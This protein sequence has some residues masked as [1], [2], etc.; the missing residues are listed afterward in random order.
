MNMNQS[1]RV[2][3]ILMRRKGVMLVP[4]SKEASQDDLSRVVATMA[5]IML[6]RGFLMSDELVSALLN[7]GMSATS[8]S[9]YCQSMIKTVDDMYGYRLYKPFYRNFPREVM[10]ADT[11]TLVI[12]AIL[13]YISGGTIVPEAK[14]QEDLYAPISN[15]FDRA[16]DINERAVRMLRLGSENDFYTMCQN[17]MTSKTSI[18]S[19]D[20]EM[21]KLFVEV[22]PNM[23]PADIPHKENKAVVIATMLE[24]GIMEHMLYAQVNSVTDVLRVA[25]ALSNGDVSL[26]DNTRYISFS[27]PIRKWMMDTLECVPGAIEEEMIKYRERWIRIGERIHP[28]SFPMD[29]Y[30]R[31]IDA[32]NLL[33]N[34]EQAIVPYG[35]KVERAFASGK[36][37]LL[38]EL[39]TQR[40]GYFAR[41]LHHMFKVFPNKHYDIAVSFAAVAHK[42]A[43]PVLLQVKSYYENEQ[44]RYGTGI[45]FPKGNT[46]RIYVKEGNAVIKITDEI[47][48]LVVIACTHGLM[49]QYR[50]KYAGVYDESKKAYIEPGLASYL[51]PNSMRSAGKALRSVPR[52]SRMKLNEND[53][54]L[55]PFIHWM[56]NENRVDVDL[57][58][59]FFD[60]Q[61]EYMDT[62]SY[63]E[64]RNEYAV[65]SGDFTNAPAPDGA[66]EFVDV[67]ID[68][69]RKQGVRYAIVAVHS[70]TEDY[71]REIPDCFVGYMTL[72]ESEY[73][74]DYGAYKPVTPFNIERV[75]MK[76]DI[77]ND[78]QYVVVCALDLE[79]NE[80]IWCD[81]AGDVEQRLRM[82]NNVENT[83]HVIGYVMQSIVDSK[84][85]S[86]YELAKMTVTAKGYSI[87]ENMDEADIVYTVEPV[88]VDGK[89]SVS[90]FDSDVW[91]AMV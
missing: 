83:K 66:C 80:I 37:E 58:V 54:H 15:M 69:A 43:T 13:H 48:N 35:S 50:D 74:K 16:C 70:Y 61:M 62:V 42:V 49:S 84:R 18:S 59:A 90:A 72:T 21:L 78:G 2:A 12:N 65:H 89:E 68:G 46:Q 77:A 6:S 4:E 51:I 34:N 87:V 32:F 39:L 88:I 1:Y 36:Y 9:A 26:K 30:E 86:M 11:A 3:D 64:L 41:E 82:P 20:K 17:L 19:F 31:T 24:C 27:R 56:N 60:S 44:Y 7:S 55:R 75:K 76:M 47:K 45:Y 33:R 81:I 28:R 29:E 23:I 10:E 91:Q 73:Q 79:T 53:K 71:F 22:A 52:G 63:Y 14:C 8:M 5:H 40:P 25:A 67:D 57:S 85:T 38:V